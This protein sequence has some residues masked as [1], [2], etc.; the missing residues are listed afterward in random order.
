MNKSDQLQH[1]DE[2]DEQSLVSDHASTFN[3]ILDVLA[4]EQMEAPYGFPDFKKPGEW[5]TLP[6]GE[7]GDCRKALI[8][9]VYDPERIQDMLYLAWKHVTQNCKGTTDS[10]LFVVSVDAGL[11]DPQWQLFK[12]KFDSEKIKTAVIV[13]GKIT[14]SISG[15]SAKL[16]DTVDFDHFLIWPEHVKDWSEAVRR[17]FCLALYCMR[18]SLLRDTLPKTI[19][20][21][22]TPPFANENLL[23]FGELPPGYRPGARFSGGTHT[24]RFKL[25]GSAFAKRLKGT[26]IWQIVKLV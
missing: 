16:C 24:V 10:V 7:E 19:G 1:E 13:I 15:I 4:E 11:W 25:D 18:N 17:K 3:G 5:N 12:P 6:F 26:K 21:Y 14:K 20:G 2:D 23:V 22:T 9:D 8:I